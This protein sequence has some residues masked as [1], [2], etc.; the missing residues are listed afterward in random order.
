MKRIFIIVFA[1]LSTSIARADEG[2]WLLSML[3]KNIATMQEM[4]MGV[5]FDSF[6]SNA[7]D[8]LREMRG[9]VSSQ[10]FSG[11]LFA[12]PLLS[13][14]S[15]LAASTRLE[16][17]PYVDMTR[18]AQ[19]KAGVEIEGGNGSYAIRGGQSYAPFSASVEADWSQAA[20]WMMALGRPSRSEMAKA[21]DL[22][23][24]PMSSR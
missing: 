14:D 16:S 15:A 5:S 6:L 10:F 11:L 24:M 13:G 19:M 7:R 17:L 4:V 3:G 8:A 1:L 18:G 20:F 23:G 2:M 21:L 12:L 22:P 9:D